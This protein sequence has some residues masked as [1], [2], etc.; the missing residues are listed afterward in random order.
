MLPG[1]LMYTIVVAIWKNRRARLQGV[2]MLVLWPLSPSE[3]A[4]C[5][6]GLAIVRYAVRL[7]CRIHVT[8]NARFNAAQISGSIPYSKWARS[9]S[10]EQTLLTL[11]VDTRSQQ[12]YRFLTTTHR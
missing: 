4:R 6:P 11:G 2:S 3:M 5:F 8:K 7:H 12:S 1:A 9:S 10:A